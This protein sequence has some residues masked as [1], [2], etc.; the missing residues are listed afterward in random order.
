MNP[1][2]RRQLKIL[3]LEPYYGGSHQAFLD[4]WRGRSRHDWTVLTLPARK[5][6]WRMRHAAVTFAEQLNCHTD[7]NCRWDV[8]FCSDM[9]N[10]A[11]L[12]GLARAASQLPSVVY[13]H[14]N[15]LF[16]P[17]RKEDPRDIHFGFINMTTAL[18][19]TEVWVNSAFH[20]D[21]FLEAL[22]KL[23]RQ[24]PDHQNLQAVESIRSKSAVHPPGID[25][26]APRGAR[27][28]GPIRILWAARWEHDKNPEAFF[29]AVRTLRR[30]NLDFRLSVIGQHFRDR[31]EV[32][33]QARRELQ[34]QIDHWGYQ[35][36]R[37]Q[38]E[39]VLLR[40]D[41]FISTAR[42]EF[43][44][45]SAA[46]AVAAGAYP[47]LP[48]R[49]AYPEVLQLASRPKMQQFFYDGGPGQLAAKLINLA[50][51]LQQGGDMWAGDP[52][53]AR[54]AVEKF[55]WARVAGEL[56]SALERAALQVG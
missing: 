32:F 7:S 29:E 33:S 27:E 56:D 5:W 19:A 8:L 50:K 3:A 48:E 13:F 18:G 45:L 54:R 1:A 14:E 31:P 36:G 30:E 4:G 52:N 10:L 34:G 46:E 21:S 17:V 22:E 23:L 42:Q 11:E 35:T 9:L 15:Q 47:L 20:R 25:E 38:Y 40:A 26:F 24:M 49:L 41:V 2:P 6:K 51:T 44:G 28:G 53:R 37:E 12:K 43:F 16:Y 55:F 39:S